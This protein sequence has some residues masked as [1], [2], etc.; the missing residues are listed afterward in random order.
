MTDIEKALIWLGAAGF[1]GNLRLVQALLDQA[2]VEIDIQNRVAK[3]LDVEPL[4]YGK[5][6]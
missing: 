3:L 5:G 6:Y 1:I 4:E 2:D